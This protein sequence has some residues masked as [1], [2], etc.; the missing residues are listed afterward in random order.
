[1]IVVHILKFSHNQSKEFPSILL[2]HFSYRL[3]PY[4]V[5]ELAV[6]STGNGETNFRE[7]ACESAN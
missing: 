4:T 1:M 3:D 5:T 2:L 6:I 7:I